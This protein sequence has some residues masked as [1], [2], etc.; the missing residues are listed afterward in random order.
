MIDQ[1]FI[2]G[3]SVWDNVISRYEL[4]RN[5]EMGNFFETKACHV[6]GLCLVAIL[7]IRTYQRE[8]DEGKEK[9]YERV[10]R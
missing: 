2:L 1:R 8:R 7:E 5:M 10:P 3:R 4:L 9:T 6:E